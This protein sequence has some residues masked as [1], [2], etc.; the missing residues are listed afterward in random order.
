MRL[1]EFDKRTINIIGKNQLAKLIEDEN[2]LIDERRYECGKMSTLV[3]D[4]AVIMLAHDQKCN[5]NIVAQVYRKDGIGGR[6]TTIN[7]YDKQM[8]TLCTWYPLR[9]PENVLTILGMARVYS[10]GIQV[11]DADFTTT[12]LS[13][14][15][16]GAEEIMAPT[17]DIV[18]MFQRVIEACEN[19][20][21][22]STHETGTL[23]L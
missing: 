19:K 8:R 21:N 14:L 23:E 13:K 6:A 12:A 17:R 10:M 1:V 18:E 11:E 3:G 9:T 2:N 16:R 5:N 22:I 7:L 15:Q 20:A 4:T